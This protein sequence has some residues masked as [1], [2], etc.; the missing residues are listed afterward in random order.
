MYVCMYVC[1][2]VFVFPEGAFATGHNFSYYK[3]FICAI[4]FISN[5]I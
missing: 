1:M 4:I 5:E 3:F 2:Y